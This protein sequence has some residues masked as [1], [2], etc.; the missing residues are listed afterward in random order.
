MLSKCEKKLNAR[1]TSIVWSRLSHR[2]LAD[3][4]DALQR[5]GARL[6]PDHLAQ[7]PAEQPPVLAQRILLVVHGNWNRRHGQA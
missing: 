1:T 7:Q 5:L 3:A 6:L 4:L 2:H